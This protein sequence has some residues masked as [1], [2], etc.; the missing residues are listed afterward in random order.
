MHVAVGVIEQSG[1]ILLAK[2]PGHAHQ[3]GLWE[4]PGGKLESRETVRQALKRELQE[5]LGITPLQSQPLIQVPHDYQ[6]KRVFLDV[7]KVTA[8]RGEPHGRENQEIR[9]VEK[10]RLK[11]FTFPAANLPILYALTLPD[12]YII[13][14]E[15][16]FSNLEHFLQNLQRT[17]QQHQPAILQ[18]RAK[19]ASFDQLA[20]LYREALPI[21]TKAGIDLY[22]NCNP[23]TARRLE[24]PNIHLSSAALLQLPVPLADLQVAASCHNPVEITRA[25]Q[26]DARF[27][28]LSPV[29]PTASH[30][31]STPMGWQNFQALC[32]QCRLPVFALGGMQAAD[33]PV[34]IGHGAQGVAGISAFWVTK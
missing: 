22:V 11:N 20:L 13:T 32:R 14:P 4:F 1:R 17:L 25:Q 30:P 19:T 6:D 24:I 12:K 9:W 21:A 2:R 26:V 33:I 31:D 29:K 16:D 15:P 3:G 7:Y 23:D 27:I 34:A 5:E 8:F 28:V 18:L 10:A